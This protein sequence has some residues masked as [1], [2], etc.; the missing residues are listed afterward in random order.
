M[1]TKMTIPNSLQEAQNSSTS[2]PSE[3]I[4]NPADENISSERT[5]WDE[6]ASDDSDVVEESGEAAPPQQ[7]DTETAPPVEETAE[8]PEQTDTPESAET[9]ETPAEAPQVE[10]DYEVIQQI[11]GKGKGENAPAKE[12]PG[13]EQP[14]ATEEQQAASPEANR[15]ALREQALTEV[16]SH[17][18]LQEDEVEEFRD[19][20]NRVLPKMF[21]KVYMDIFDSLMQGMQQQLP[22]AVQFVTQQQA[23]H[24]EQVNQ[25]YQVWPQLNTDALRPVVDRVAEAYTAVNPNVPQ[26]QRIR[27]IGAQ[28]WIAAQL[29]LESLN[30]H[31]SQFD[32]SS[33]QEAP[34]APAF[35]K[36]A[37]NGG[38]PAQERLTAA[39]KNA[40]DEFVEESILDDETY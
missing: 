32:R 30:A 13:T 27:E 5:E 15:D 36:P 26:G 35:R 16:E 33:Q 37:G 19:D 18:Q 8:I 25:F 17:F 39:P 22:Q 34:A 10:P 14:A 31:V 23:D 29:P 7:E 24:N 9:P 11:L 38:A 6:L 20:P 40:W 1:T 4:A 3:E 12:T 21:A 28:A 2:E